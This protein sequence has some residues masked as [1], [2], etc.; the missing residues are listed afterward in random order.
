M[1]SLQHS[2]CSVIPS[3]AAVELARQ[4]P[5]R[6]TLC[7]LCVLCG[8]DRAVSATK[9]LLF[10]LPLQ[11]RHSTHMPLARPAKSFVSG[12]GFSHA[13]A[14]PWGNAGFS[15][16]QQMPN[17]SSSRVLV[18]HFCRHPQIQIVVI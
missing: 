4:S 11:S 8:E 5:S 9:D 17:S 7:F 14:P 6:G 2:Y 13:A 3:E 16:C 15:R 12:H 10:A 18:A 1:L